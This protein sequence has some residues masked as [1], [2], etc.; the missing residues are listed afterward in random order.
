MK[1]IIKE[2]LEDFKFIKEM[3]LNKKSLI[4]DLLVMDYD[5]NDALI[6]LDNLIEWY[7]SLPEV[8]ELFRII[9]VDDYDEINKEEP[10]SHYSPEK[11]SLLDS[12]DFTYGYGDIEILMT[13]I[14]KKTNIDVQ[15]TLSNNILYP[16]EKEITLKNNGKGAKIINL[17]IIED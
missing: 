3:K 6:E 5:Y 2:K 12:N 16:N 14:T 13:I 4:H 8:L 1:K 15:Q 11:E 7:K 9:Y 17:E 10:G